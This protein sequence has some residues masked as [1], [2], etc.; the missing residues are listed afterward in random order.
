MASFTDHSDVEFRCSDEFDQTDAEAHSSKI[1]EVFGRLPNV[2][3]SKVE[4]FDVTGGK[5]FNI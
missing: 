2:F 1:A 5:L 4:N 3:R